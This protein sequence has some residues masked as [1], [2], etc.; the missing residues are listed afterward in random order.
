MSEM[1]DPGGIPA[2]VKELLKGFTHH[3]GNLKV[4]S[5]RLGSVVSIEISG[6]R[7]DQPKLIGS[8]GGHIAAMNTL[9]RAVG[10]KCGVRIVLSLKEPTIGVKRPPQAFVPNPNWKPERTLKLLQSIVSAAIPVRF[11]IGQHHDE[12]NSVFEIK[13][14]DGKPIDADV[15]SALETIFDAV[16]KANGRT[17]I[18]AQPSA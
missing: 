2:L 12:T 15:F 5:V 10:K 3:H 1:N 13:P 7:D 8:K 16:G 17:V 11:R 4:T 9:M 18:I 14:I 6:N